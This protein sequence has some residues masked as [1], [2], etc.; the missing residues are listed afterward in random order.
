MDERLLKFVQELN[1]YEAEVTAETRIYHDL[2]VYG[3]DA[4]EFLVAY[5]EMFNVNLSCFV[6]SDYFPDEGFPF[7]SE[8]LRIILFRPKKRYKELSVGKLEA[9]ITTGFLG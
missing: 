9:G 6:F 7:I 8:I 3:D 4:E 2:N 1:P 5:A